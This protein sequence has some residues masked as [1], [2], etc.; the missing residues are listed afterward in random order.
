MGTWRGSDSLVVSRVPAPVD[1]L[2]RELSFE[3]HGVFHLGQLEGA[4]LTRSAREYR[5]GTGE[6]VPVFSG[7]YR[8]A[9][10]PESW[11]G[12]VLA[13]C[14]AG[15]AGAR[16]SH[17]TAA[18]LWALPGKERLPIEI[19]CRRW[20]RAQH[21]GIVV[22]ETK[23]LDGPAAVVD[24]IP[25]TSAARTLLDLGSGCSPLTVE[26][27]VDNALRRGL[28]SLTDLSRLLDRLGRSGRNGA[29]ILRSILDERGGRAPTESEMETL[30]LA[31][32]KRQGLPAP[33]LQH[34]VID[35]GGFVAR[36]DAAYPDAKIAIEYESYQHHIGRIP[37]VRDS[38]RRNRMI[39]AHW[40]VITAT[41]VD[42]RS[43]G[44]DLCRAIRASLAQR[45]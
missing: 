14:W 40:I 45:S 13:A 7:I 26:M 5:V 1:E 21:A 43:G 35:D 10:A 41:A 18:T 12:T 44:R 33:V 28:V 39:A 30:L 6:W 15:G 34:V 25:V 17:R 27:A 11:R 32:I 37:L 31:V 36:C 2:T 29:G 19:T 42:L 24:G 16:A 8:L 20:R 9:G 3:Q 23:A 4:R 38:A 22:H